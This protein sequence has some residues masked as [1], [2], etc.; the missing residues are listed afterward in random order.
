MKLTLWS[1]FNNLYCTSNISDTKNFGR[2]YVRTHL[3]S[4]IKIVRIFSEVMNRMYRGVFETDRE[5][6]PERFPAKNHHQLV[7]VCFINN[8]IKQVNSASWTIEP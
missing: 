1:Y 6:I 3:L 8:K 5:N 7:F 4:E 2:F